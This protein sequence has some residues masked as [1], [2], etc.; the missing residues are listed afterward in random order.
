MCCYRISIRYSTLS[1]FGYR[2]RCREVKN[3]IRTS[4]HVC[5]VFLQSLGDQSLNLILLQRQPE[6]DVNWERQEESQ[7]KGLYDEVHRFSVFPA[8]YRNW[9]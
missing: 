9:Y 2:N 8:W 5:A 1:K 7:H 3:G 6:K 4:L